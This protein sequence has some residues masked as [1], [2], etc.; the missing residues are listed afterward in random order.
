MK[1]LF[2]K[3]IG[4]LLSILMSVS[5][6]ACSTGRVTTS[7]SSKNTSTPSKSSEEISTSTNQSQ[8]SQGGNTSSGSQGGTSSGEGG[9]LADVS[10]YIVKDSNI[11]LKLHYD[12]QAP[13][14]NECSPEA[15][16]MSGHDVGW[17][18]WS[19][20]IGN[21]YFGANVFGRTESERVQ[22]TEKT[23]S[24]PWQY[25]YND[26]TTT[27]YPA[28][29]GLNNFSETYI[30]FNHTNSEVTNYNRYLDLNT[31]ISGVSYTY[32]GVNYTREYFTSYPDK[33]LV[34]R[35]DASS[36]GALGF[37][38][39]PTI[40][41]KQEYMKYV[42]DGFSK[43]GEVVSSVSNGIGCIELT[44]KL[45]YYDVDFV[46]Q[47]RVY[48]NG[49]TVK[50]TSCVNSYGETD[51]T[52]TVSGATS[53]Y[54]V[55][56]LGTDYELSS[57]IFKTSQYS[58]DKP[59]AKTTLE[60]AKAKVNGYL[61]AIT[62][63]ISGKSFEEAYS[64]LKD[65]HLA[66]YQEIFDRVDVNIN[67]T[68]ADFN[69]TTDVLLQNYVNGNKS[70]YLD[71]LLL[72]Y[73]R[74]LIVASSRKGT[75]PANLQGAWNCYN[76]PAWSSGYWNNVNIQMNYWHAF[77]TNVA[78]TFESY[79]DFNLAFLEAAQNNATN[80]IQT[81]NPS[82][83]GKD[84]GNGW[85]IGVASNPFF[86]G[87]DRSCGNMG[88]TTQLYWDYY[89][90]TKDP[91][92]LELVYDMLV[93]AARYVTK[94]VKEYDGLY[95][96]E[97]SD[98]PEMYVNG[99]W[100][101]TT[102]TTYAQSL[103][104]LNNY[105][106]LECAKELGIDIENSA[107]LSESDKTILKT[108]L[109]QIDKYD[110]I[111]VG[112]S[113]QIKE[114]REETY[115]AS[116]GDPIHRHI[117]QLVGLYPGNLINGTTEAWLDASVV[118]LEGRL[119]GLEF[120]EDWSNYDKSEASMVGWSWVH[121]AALFARAGQGDRALDMM[122]GCLK[123]ATLNNLLMVCGKVFQ[124]EASCGTSAAYAEMLLQSQ[125]G[126]IAPLP[127]VPTGWTTGSYK[128]LVARGNFEVSAAW[129]N[130]LATSFNILSKNGGKVAV[131][132]P[133]I[134]EAKVYTAD[135]KSISYKVEGQDLISF[136]TIQGETYVIV[137]FK[138]VE[139]P[140]KVAALD[141]TRNGLQEFNFA[142][143]KVSGATSY[144]VYVAIENDA[145]YTLIGTVT[146]NSFSYTM[147]EGKENVR[148]TFAI[149]SVNASG[150]ESARTLCYY[151]PIECGAKITNVS[152]GVLA[153]GNIQAVVQAENAGKYLLMELKQ[154]ESTY[155]VIAES[156]YPTIIGGSYTSTSKYAIAVESHLD[157]SL[158]DKW[159]LASSYNVNNILS[160]KKFIPTAEALNQVYSYSEGY[161]YDGLTDG[162]N[163]NE[164]SGRFSSKLSTGI[165]DATVDLEGSYVLSEFRI[166]DFNADAVNA[167]KDLKIEVLSGGVWTTI[168]NCANNTEIE[169]H[170]VTGEGGTGWLSFDMG[171]AEAEKIR[172]YVSA[173]SAS[174]KAITFYE[175]E[176][177]GI[178]NESVGT[179]QENIFSGKAFTPSTQG[180]NSIYDA[181][182]GYQTL[183]DGILYKEST[184]RFSSKQNGL[185]DGTVALNGIYKLSK[186]KIH[187]Y[188]DD[189]TKAGSAIQVDV[190]YNG[191]W[192]TVKNI[193]NAN[194][195]ELVVDNPNGTYDYICID[196]DYVLA[197]Q[198]RV[199]V[200]SCTSSGWITFYEIECSGIYVGEA[201]ATVSQ[202]ILSDK[203][204]V[205][206]AE[207]QE[208]ILSATWWKGGGYEDLTDGIKNADNAAGRFST[209]M[210]TSGMMDATVD[211][212]AVYRLDELRFYLYDTG[213]NVV[214]DTVGTDLL[215]QIYYNGAWSDV[216]TCVD[217]ASIITYL[218]STTGSYNDYLA[219]NLDGILAEKI[220]FY[221]S[222]SVTASG[223]T[224]E[225]I[226]CTGLYVGDVSGM[227]D[228]VF[229]NKTF[230]PTAEAQ[231]NILIKSWWKGGGYEDLTDGIKNADNAA[232]RFSTVMATSGMMDATIDL[233]GVYELHN[234]KF[235]LYDKGT[236][237]VANTVGT[238]LLVQ[239]YYNGIWSNV[240]VC[241]NN[242]AIIANLVNGSGTY[243]AYLNFNLGGVKAEK[244]RF[245][246]S[247]SVTTDG[248]TF[249]E[250]ECS[251]MKVADS[252][253]INITQNILEGVSA[254][255]NGTQSATNKL[256]NMFD[257]N[258][259]TYAEVIGTNGS[260]AVTIDLGS[261]KAVYSLSIKELIPSTNLVG[262]VLATA[263]DNT[264]VQIYK[265]GYWLTVASKVTLNADG[266]TT[267]NLY[268]VECTQI[269]I[270]FTNTRLFDGQTEKTTAKICEIKCSAFALVDRTELLEAL[271]K[272]SYAST[273]NYNYVYTEVYKTYALYASEI[274]ATQE[275]VDAYTAEVEKYLEK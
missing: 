268:G 262:G 172:I 29:G 173:P 61:S 176:C 110:P 164:F 22:I 233:D 131:K 113:G 198:I 13:F 191:V 30:D 53:A 69:T 245:Y 249:E 177:S 253:S 52:I 107:V 88:F 86:I 246:I 11:P 71:A 58:K 163:Y 8:S 90:F 225:E 182:Y 160:G 117:S 156:I 180:A 158:S 70:T 255:T 60:D 138:R 210:S 165:V 145:K 93:E 2:K 129:E 231:E 18:S 114:F 126:Y 96:V 73:G 25:V 229:N 36:S 244:V 23:L 254:T 84:G 232:G 223:T 275:M 132:Y 206:T 265:D 212:G 248:T 81:H 49:G 12:E 122:A 59:T 204:F 224:Y 101:Y 261:P 35:L 50:A 169:S 72:Q 41:F 270:I 20:P 134:T 65:R 133:S 40:P 147:P 201:K 54:I 97:Y 186:L 260:Y 48:T 188:K 175:I 103:A 118:S 79:V 17:Q 44:G 247:A 3:Y 216:V 32:N 83:A 14:D 82:V 194:F 152:W 67:C 190:L 155:N 179:Y 47:Y 21:G 234:L 24:N 162:V 39:R 259:A 209:V 85:T 78:E 10:G 170:R 143:E 62:Q 222:A 235:F 192:T 266:F 7:T 154:G 87:G 136:E 125:E 269:N 257:N 56:T 37:V 144:K 250:I 4:I 251:G 92:V 55:V 27:S 140:N 217:N 267:I 128:G 121:K 57:E 238:D 141:Y 120:F 16:M 66:D 149:T 193:A 240:V 119:K 75:L 178:V 157:G 159:I 264:V 102:G 33:A 185:L 214:A 91:E 77:S 273:E 146:G 242:A 237:A 211:L 109:E 183:T 89:Q 167:G 220:R 203:L 196:L 208:K 263:S 171:G 243:D 252:N 28:I 104:Y 94:C 230:V 127:A 124:I 9:S 15:S 6:V 64:Y 161:G 153:N 123:G 219:F 43:T 74:Y 227:V 258:D 112:L 80:L 181:P 135:G 215:I 226:E 207:A 38:L 239:V 116:M 46:G 187:L 221:I 148:T 130:G 199:Y 111:N 108:I 241:E 150:R 100:Y 174:G 236:N 272:I 139:T 1:S 42:N 184:G 68:Q 45:G 256:S 189:L 115:Y 166:Y 205:P 271:N 105:A 228:N 151:N 202:N 195:G 26:G 19:L 99:V 137:D 95:L 218:V 142:W 31:A 98:S 34:I 200:P 168:I 213:S 5:T 274:N 76:I 51:G 106:V 197:E 63:G